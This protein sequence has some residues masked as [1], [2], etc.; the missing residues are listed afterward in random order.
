MGDLPNFERGQIVRVCLAG[1]SVKKTVI[2]LGVLTAKVSTVMSA[3]TIHGKTTSS[4]RNS[5]QK[6]T[7]TE[8][9]HHTSRRIV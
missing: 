8:R 7:L 2:L 3:Y 9:D 5:E 1:A 4:K 6:S